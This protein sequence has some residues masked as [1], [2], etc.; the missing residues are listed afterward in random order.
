MPAECGSGSM[1]ER[2]ATNGL[3][4]CLLHMGWSAC[5][6]VPAPLPIQAYVSIMLP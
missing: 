2:L 1:N 4:L 5:A 3:V 6:G